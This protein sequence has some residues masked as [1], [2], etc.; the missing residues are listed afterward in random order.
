MDITRWEKRD[1]LLASWLHM[2]TYHMEEN[3]RKPYQSMK[4]GIRD[5]LWGTCNINIPLTHLWEA[6]GQRRPHHIW[7]LWWCGHKLTCSINGTVIFPLPHEMW[8]T[9]LIDTEAKL[10]FACLLFPRRFC[11]SK[12]A[13]YSYGQLKHFYIVLLGLD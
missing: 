1:T 10:I 2:G 12:L 4:A 7:V 5:R 9:K 11:I 8:N 13:M 6:Q 3:G